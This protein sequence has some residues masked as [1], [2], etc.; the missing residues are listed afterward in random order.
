MIERSIDE[1]V[2][3][4]FPPAHFGIDFRSS[5]RLRQSD[6]F[7]CSTVN[8]SFSLSSRHL[9]YSFAMA[10]RLFGEV[11]AYSRQPLT[12]THAQKVTRLYRRSL[13]LADSWTVNREIFNQ[14]ATEIR[15]RFDAN[16]KLGSESG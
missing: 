11:Q 14:Q 12:L 3:C 7:Y 15:A 13:R 5:L 1:L 4:A 9:F 2:K 6:E 10:M 16:K 8:P